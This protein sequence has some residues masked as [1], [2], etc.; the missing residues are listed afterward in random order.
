[1]GTWGS[2]NFENDAAMEWIGDLRGSGDADT[3][4]AALEAVTEPGSANDL[5]AGEAAQALAA[6]EVVAVAI[7]HPPTVDPPERETLDQLKAWVGDHPQV[8]VL[9][10]LARRAV[11]RV[12]QPGC[13]LRELW[14]EDAADT[15]QW[16]G[17]LDDLRARLVG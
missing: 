14:F 7:G 15:E 17:V 9:G 12:A 16:T 10:P 1:M 3:V 5:D 8:S 4:K 11:D 2:G 6:A 13:E